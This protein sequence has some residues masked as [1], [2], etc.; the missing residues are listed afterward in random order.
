MLQAP[1]FQPLLGND[2]STEAQVGQDSSLSD[3]PAGLGLFIREVW[4]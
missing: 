4:A 2:L 3:A 1:L